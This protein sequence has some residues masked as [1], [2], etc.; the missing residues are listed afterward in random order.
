LSYRVRAR[1]GFRP[2]RTTC[3]WRCFCQQA[4]QRQIG[5]RWPLG[6]TSI[7]KRQPCV[8]LIRA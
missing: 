1:G 6:E 2:S 7:D 5:L 8:E 3:A 4:G